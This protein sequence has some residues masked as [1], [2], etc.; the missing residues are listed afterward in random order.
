MDSDLYT[1]NLKFTLKITKANHA[2]VMVSHLN[3]RD[4]HMY[5]K[6]DF[7]AR[8]SLE[9]ST[10]D[11]SH[12]MLGVHG[13]LIVRLTTSSIGWVLMKRIEQRFFSADTTKCLHAVDRRVE[14]RRKPTNYGNNHHWDIFNG[15][16]RIESRLR[17]P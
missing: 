4:V 13:V 17:R 11:H 15:R 9:V 16:L 14:G 3:D 10:K 5:D 2:S 8:S 6:Y 1:D 7:S 12:E